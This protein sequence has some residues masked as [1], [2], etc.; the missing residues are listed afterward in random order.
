MTGTSEEARNTIVE[1]FRR[2]LVGPMPADLAPGD[3]DLQA[4]CLSE[5]PCSWYLTGFIAP[6]EECAGASSD[7]DADTQ[8]ETETDA[9]DLDDN[10]AGIAD[11]DD[12][13]PDAPT[14]RRRY[15]PSSIGLTVLVPASVDAV[16]VR[17]SWGDYV[18]EPPLSANVLIPRTWTSPRRLASPARANASCACRCRR[19]ARG[20]RSSCR[21]ARRSSGR[22]VHSSSW[23]MRARSRSWRR[24]RR[25]DRCARSAFSWSTA[26]RPRAVAMPMSPMPFRRGS[27]ST[28]RR[29][30]WPRRDLS[31]YPLDDEDQRIA[32]L[33]YRDEAE[34]AVGRNIS[35]GWEAPDGGGRRAP[36][37]DRSAADCRGRA[38]G[39]ERG[40]SPD[41]EFGMEALAELAAAGGAALA[42]ALGGLAGQYAAWIETSAACWTACRSGG[43][44]TGARLIDAM[45]TARK[46]GSPPASTLCAA[47][48]SAH[49]LSH[50]QPR[51]RTGGAAALAV[52]RNGRPAAI[53]AEWR[54]FQLAFILLNLAGLVEKTHADRELVDLLFFPT[55]GGK[56][57]AY[58]GLAAFT[59]AHRRARRRAGC[60]APASPS[61][62]ATRFAC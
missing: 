50:R 16:D 45:E 2:D 49:R 14:T 8:E 21:T 56:T 41:V 51:G 35:A 46:R 29:A 47:T 19:A 25:R 59:I 22:A 52:G 31:G 3:A 61:S 7:D 23:L 12:I 38:G 36:R 33:H 6:L 4:E 58:L 53:A 20:G 48:R 24:V 17:L 32:D 62:C 26:A 57:E 39:A 18:T 34:Y 15:L 9:G 54:P 60:S 30:W 44:E 11:D 13:P 10:G 43:V 42:G 28:A 5:A 55:G 40:R 1:L 27:R 37:L